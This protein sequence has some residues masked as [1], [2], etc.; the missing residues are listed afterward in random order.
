MSIFANSEDPDEMQ[1]NATTLFEKVKNI[2]RQ[3]NIILFENYNLT[4]LDITLIVSNQKDE[5]IGIL[6]VKGCSR[7]YGTIF[8]NYIHI[9]C[10]IMINDIMNHDFS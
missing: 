4:P 8:L 1:H 3:K 7:V 2:F 6:R 10:Q 9:V 5:S